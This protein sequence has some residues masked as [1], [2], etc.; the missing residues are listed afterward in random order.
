MFESLAQQGI[1][2]GISVNSPHSPLSFEKL[3]TAPY[4]SSNALHRSIKEEQMSLARDTIASHAASELQWYSNNI[5]VQQSKANNLDLKLEF[6]CEEAYEATKM[7]LHAYSA[8]DPIVA[9]EKSL[10]VFPNCEA[11]NV[12]AFYKS[13]TLEEALAWYQKGAAQVEVCV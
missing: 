1:A 11:Y 12:L 5:L 8:E 13:S 3:G 6:S 2:V 10:A 4:D 7:A 9:A